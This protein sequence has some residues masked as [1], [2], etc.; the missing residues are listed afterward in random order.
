MGLQGALKEFSP[1]EL[2]QLLASGK[3]TCELRIV[4]SAGEAHVFFDRGALIHAELRDATGEAVLPEVVG[5]TDGSFETLPPPAEL[6]ARTIEKDLSSIILNALKQ[7]AEQRRVT[8]ERGQ[9]RTMPIATTVQSVL[10]G[11]VQNGGSVLHLSVF[12]TRGAV[13]AQ[14]SD[15]ERAPEAVPELHQSSMGFLTG[16]PRRGLRRVLLDD[17]LGIVAIARLDDARF[18]MALAAAGT[19]PGALSLCLGKVAAQLAAVEALQLTPNQ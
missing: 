19:Q 8:S 2:L 1:V 9:R 4:S 5:W 10:E 12:D 17:A 14:A 6:P 11:W 16:Y 13:L 18:L 7:N 15:R 3:K